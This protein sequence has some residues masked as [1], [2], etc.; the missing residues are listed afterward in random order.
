[1]QN[2]S[3][4]VLVIGSSAK[5]YALVQKL[6]TYGCEVIV[7]PGNIRIKDIAECVDIRE[8]STKELLEYVLENAADLTI[9]SSDL[10]IKSDI[11]TLFQSNEQMIFAPSADSAEITIS[12]SSAKKFLYRLRIPTP[13]FGVFDKIQP[14]IDYLKKAQMPQVIRSDEAFKGQDRLVCTTFSA[15]KTFVEDLFASDT[16]KIVSEDYVYGHEFTFYTVTDGYHAIPLVSVAN[17][18][19]MENGDGGVLTSG[20]GAYAPDYKISNDIEDYLMKN[21]V[22]KVLQALESKGTPYLGILGID[23]V[24]KDDGQ[25]VVLDFKSFLQDHDAKVVLNLIDENLPALFEACS[26]G[27]FADDYESVK[28]SENSSVSAV[29]STRNA[30]R[31]IEGLNFV[32]SDFVPFGISKNDYMEFLT[33]KGKNFV[34]T[35]TASTLSR[36]RKH[37]YDDLSCIKFD[38]IKYRTDICEQVEKF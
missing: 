4:K 32:D 19:F 12:R 7:A 18:K 1:M 8:D 28:I 6:Q 9:A 3:K 26:V 36:A 13:K 14:A 2:R 25:V 27:S 30:N 31:I 20:V 5:E 11:A 34:L 22:N 23:C 15:A 38:G 21:V 29:V 10:A 24:L 37:L 16:K 17:Y 35:N 33:V